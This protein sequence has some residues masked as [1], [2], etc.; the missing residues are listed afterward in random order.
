[1]DHIGID[2]H[3]RDNQIRLLAE[4]LDPFRHT[5][6]RSRSTRPSATRASRGGAARVEGAGLDP[7]QIV[8]LHPDGLTDAVAALGPQLERAKDEHTRV[9]WR[10]SRR[11]SSGG[12]D[13][14]VDSLKT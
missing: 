14:V 8:G 13:T 12:L 5:E 9:P 6:G 1:M 3:K 11:R 10:S 2:V 7:E 4:G